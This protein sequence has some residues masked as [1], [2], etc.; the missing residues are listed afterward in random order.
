[1]ARPKA[2]FL[3]YVA[4]N[5][6]SLVNAVEKVGYEVHWI[7]HPSDISNAEVQLRHAA[8]WSFRLTKCQ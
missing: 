5:I 3:D 8:S 6:R 1:M 4:G 7:K 2:F